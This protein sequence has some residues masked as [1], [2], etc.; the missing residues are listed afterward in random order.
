MVH[1]LDQIAKSDAE[2]EGW[3]ITNAGEANVA[4]ALRKLGYKP[5][6]IATQFNLGPY[7]LDFAL[8]AERID[9]EADGWVHTAR[10]VRRRDAARDRQLRQW[11]WTVV[12]IDL[13]EDI[14]AQ[15]KRKVPDQTLREEWAATMGQLWAVFG[16]ALDRLARRGIDDPADRLNLVRG[17]MSEAFKD[18]RLNPPRRAQ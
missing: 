16:V 10:D 5:S 1:P 9:I 14:G 12:R 7:K 18:P 2:R 13:G 8:V 11:G 15:L 6:D 4:L 17:V 3:K